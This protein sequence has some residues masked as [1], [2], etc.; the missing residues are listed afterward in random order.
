MECYGGGDRKEGEKSSPNERGRR[1]GERG[2]ENLEGESR[3]SEG[4]V[5][6][7]C[8]DHSFMGVWLMFCD[9]CSASSFWIVG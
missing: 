1:E 4:C 5:N 6:T 2:S 9:I 7:H 8:V 3:G